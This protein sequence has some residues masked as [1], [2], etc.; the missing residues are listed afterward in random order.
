MRPTR[1]QL[2]ILS[3]IGIRLALA[4]V[5]GHP[6]DMGIYAFTQRVYFQDGI[7]GLKTLSV[8]P[9]IFF[10]QLPFYAIYASLEVLG[11]GDV[12]LMY[13]TSLMLESVFLKAPF[14]LGDIGIFLLIQK[15]TGRLLPATLFFL[16][17]LTIFESS[18]WGI[19][20]SSMLLAVVYGLLLMKEGRTTA[21]SLAFVVG[22]A[23]KLFGFLPYGMLLLRNL[24]NRQFRSLAIQILSGMIITA[25]TVMPIVLF[26]GFFLFLTGF[27]FRFIGL[28]GVTVLTNYS[29]LYLLF[30]NSLNRIPSPTLLVLFV[31]SSLFLIETRQRDSL[32]ALLKW[33][34]VGAILLNIFSQAEPQWLS[35]IV[36]LAIIYGSLTQRSGLQ[37]YTFLYGVAST[38]FITTMAEPGTGFETLGLQTHFLPFLEGYQNTLY[39]YAMM[40]FVLLLLM[41]A[42]IF[43]KPIKFRFE[44]IAVVALAYLQAYF[45]L[46]VVNVPHI[47]GVA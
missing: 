36:P 25:L 12:Q 4:P 43:Y 9:L 41:S 34:L 31:V 24:I 23:L 14:I 18:A 19:Y 21:S 40:T 20:D 45:W 35:W 22:G 30:R 2:V 46:S 17:P 33:T 47:L 6:Y 38:V 26:G 7:V 27:L 44:I 13:H 10:I 29:I 8:L 15:I 11:L 5:A 1:K 42:Y 37:V 28:S 16:N 39:V 3:G 32:T